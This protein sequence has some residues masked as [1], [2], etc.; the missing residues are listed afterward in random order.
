MELKRISGSQNK[1][2]GMSS[3]ISPSR[4]GEKDITGN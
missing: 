1:G 2:M 3:R 4:G